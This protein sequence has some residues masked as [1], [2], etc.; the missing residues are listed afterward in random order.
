MFKFYKLDGIFIKE[1]YLPKK[2]KNHE[3]NRETVFTFYLHSVEL[4]S[5]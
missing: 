4:I 5:F 3:K 1:F 2:K